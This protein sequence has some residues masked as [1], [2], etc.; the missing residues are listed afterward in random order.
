MVGAVH[1]EPARAIE[2]NRPYQMNPDELKGVCRANAST[3][4]EQEDES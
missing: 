1:P 4:L 3:N 2:V